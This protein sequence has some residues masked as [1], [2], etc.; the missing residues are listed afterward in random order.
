MSTNTVRI[1][2]VARMKFCAVDVFE[3]DEQLALILL[4]RNPI[5]ELLPEAPNVFDVVDVQH[6][7]HLVAGSLR[8]LLHNMEETK[9][10]SDEA[11]SMLK[12][13]QS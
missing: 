11:I 2:F 10:S 8:K 6:L 5:V 4:S 12:A 1:Y 9:K 7:F 13:E 3:E